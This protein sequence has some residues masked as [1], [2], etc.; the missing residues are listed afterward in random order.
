MTYDEIKQKI[1]ELGTEAAQE[2]EKKLEEEKA[3]LDTE[4][5]RKVRKFWIAACVVSFLIGF[6]FSYI[7]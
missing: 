7:L 1:R 4:T 3:E 5:R 6:T 2:I